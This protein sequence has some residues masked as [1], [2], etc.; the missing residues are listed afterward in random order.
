NHTVDL[1]DANSCTA[2]GAIGVGEATAISL[3]LSKTDAL[4]I[5]AA[6]GTVTATFSGATLPY[7]V[8][9][10]G[11]TFTAQTSPYT[12]TGLAAGN[13]TVDLKDANSCTATG[14][15]GV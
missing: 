12:F 15:I 3:V 10:D 8:T 9:I 5:G 14:A 4:C 1:K 6:S 13:H 7:T 11:G 2:T